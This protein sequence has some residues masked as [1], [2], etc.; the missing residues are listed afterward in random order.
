MQHDQAVNIHPVM[1][2]A[3]FTRVENLKNLGTS[4][5]AIHLVMRQTVVG[6]TSTGSALFGEPTQMPDYQSYQFNF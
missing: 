2:E 6:Q 5:V 4:G 3:R 1:E